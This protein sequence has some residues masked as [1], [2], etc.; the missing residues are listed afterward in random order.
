MGGMS[1]SENQQ[2]KPLRINIVQGAFLPVPPL[3]GGAVEKAWYALGREFAKQGHT[4]THLGRGLAQLP[5]E[6]VDARVRYL[7][8]SGFDTP[9]NMVQLKWRDLR[10]SFAIR[11][12]LPPGD[13]LVSNTFWLPI[14]E[15]RKS[16]GIMYIHVARYPKGQLKFYPN[17]AILQTVSEPMRSAILEETPQTP[18]N[19]SVIP[20][21]L[22]A[23]YFKGNN[24][25]VSPTVLLY[26][27]R[28]HPEKGLNMLILGFRKFHEKFPGWK[29]QI[30][31]PW[32]VKHG[33]GGGPYLK[34]LK[35]LAGGLP[36]E[37]QEPEFNEERLVSVYEKAAIF[38]Y[39]SLAER[40][41]TFGLAVL[42][43]MARGCVPVVSG[44]ACF[45]DFVKSGQNGEIFDHRQSDASAQL[46]A[47]LEI[48]AADS[49]RLEQMSKR[50]RITAE[51][52]ALPKIAA[53]FVEDFYRR[54]GNRR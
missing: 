43:A 15:R 35:G 29:L 27:G 40:G 53:M 30:M 20:Y 7:R 14:I 3:M 39:P 19:I 25:T 18:G 38:V 8:T 31:G 49:E 26:T 50:A 1:D 28:I 12:L 33:G 2:R 13:I 11:R 24:P 9:K 52:F 4:V 10:Y 5:K 23:N 44:L 51:S 46:A 48:L 41:E 16:R 45:T 17:A 34:Q 6:N 42:E 21:P 37:F 36:I 47:K 22:S 54:T 32:E